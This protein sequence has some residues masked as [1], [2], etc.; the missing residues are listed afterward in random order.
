MHIM[1]GAAPVP[2][3]LHNAAAPVRPAAADPARRAL[4]GEQEDA[5]SRLRDAD[6]NFDASQR[7]G[8]LADLTG[9][10]G[11]L[12]HGWLPADSFQR[13]PVVMLR[14]QACS[15]DGVAF[16]EDNLGLEEGVLVLGMRDT[17]GGA[18]SY[19]VCQWPEG[20]PFEAASIFT[21]CIESGRS[22]GRYE[23]H[24]SEPLGWEAFLDRLS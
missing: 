18:D 8:F 22:T 23:I 1:P 24:V 10:V 20:A 12:T 19:F 13:G 21:V 15:R 9:P 11:Y 14:E 17:Q 16:G 3:S 5:L 2:A 6:L 4:P 7:A